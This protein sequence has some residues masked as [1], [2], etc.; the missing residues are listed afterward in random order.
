PEGSSDGD[1]GR[2]KSSNVNKE[3]DYKMQITAANVAARATVGGDDM[4]SKWQVMAEQ[5]RQKHE[6]GADS[7]STSQPSLDVGPKPVSTSER[8]LNDNLD[9]EKTY[10]PVTVTVTLG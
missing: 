5:E 3:E 7:A 8:T 4:L 9:T 6:G 2:G 1:D 10:A